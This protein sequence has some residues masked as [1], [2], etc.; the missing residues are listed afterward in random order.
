MNK[1]DLAA[2][3]RQLALDYLA[4]HQAS[5]TVAVA[6]HL[7]LE[8]DHGLRL[9][10]RMHKI[11]EVARSGTSKTLTWTAL[12]SVTAT[13][14]ELRSRVFCGG[15]KPR[16]GKQKRN[17]LGCRRYV[18]SPDERDGGDHP[19]PKQGGQGVAPVHRTATALEMMA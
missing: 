16:P 19:L 17:D 3:R 1:Y 4:E 2:I 15:N 6:A 18:H 13:A 9:L 11:G 5:R 8:V 7:G 10:S 12:V 14:E